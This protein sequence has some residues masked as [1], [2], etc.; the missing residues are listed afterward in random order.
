MTGSREGEQ[1]R[2]LHNANDA[3]HPPD[4][5]NKSSLMT[6][7]DLYRQQQ[8]SI[9][10]AFLFVG[11]EDPCPVRVTDLSTRLLADKPD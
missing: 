3:H 10:S 4:V 8:H 9:T 2:R 6:E 7:I 5:V 1:R 11:S